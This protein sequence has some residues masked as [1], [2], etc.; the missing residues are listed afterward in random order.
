MLY[1]SV[2]HEHIHKIKKTTYKDKLYEFQ[3]SIP[4]QVRWYFPYKPF[5]AKHF[6][7]K[8]VTIV[9]Q[10]CARGQSILIFFTDLFG[11]KKKKKLLTSVLPHLPVTSS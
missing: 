2:C 3:S 8:Y 10:T 7:W 6:L 5:F 1:H 9:L 11:T 4:K